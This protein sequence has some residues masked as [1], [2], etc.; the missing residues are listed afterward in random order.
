MR[1]GEVRFRDWNDNDIIV[2]NSEDWIVEVKVNDQDLGIV[3]C[4]GRIK[5]IWAADRDESH[6]LF[7]NMIIDLIK[8]AWV[9]NESELET[10]YE[11]LMEVID[12]LV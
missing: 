12:E 6:H 3:I 11:C 9:H 5:K 2:T 7:V 8:Q 1:I 4:P 10:L